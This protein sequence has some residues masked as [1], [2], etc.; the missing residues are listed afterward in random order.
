MRG[1]SNNKKR[2]LNMGAM[3]NVDYCLGS[4]SIQP[5]DKLPGIPIPMR[6]YFLLAMVDYLE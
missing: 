6:D 4:T 1:K 2:S 3:M 5:E